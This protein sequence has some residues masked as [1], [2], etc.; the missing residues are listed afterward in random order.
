VVLRFTWEDVMFR[1]DWVRRVIARAVGH[2]DT[3]T[4]LATRAFDAA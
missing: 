3:R 1:P 4:Q 2:V